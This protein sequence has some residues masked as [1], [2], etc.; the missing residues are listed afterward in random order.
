MAEK[1]S[2]RII[3]IKGPRVAMERRCQLDPAV[4]TAPGQCDII[5]A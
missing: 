1:L 5:V 3:L 4:Y 2:V